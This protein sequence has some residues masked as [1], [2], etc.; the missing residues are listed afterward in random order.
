MKRHKRPTEPG[1]YW[2]HYHEGW[3]P[4]KVYKVTYGLFVKMFFTIWGQN[5][6]SLK[7]WWGPKIGELDP[8]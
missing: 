1:Y 2:Y 5:I 7:G 8:K 6:E 3:Q 4:V